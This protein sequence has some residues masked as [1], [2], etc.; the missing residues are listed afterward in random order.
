MPTAIGRRSVQRL[1]SRGATLIDVLPEE[2]FENEHIAGAIHI[3][4][5]NL[6]RQSTSQLEKHEPVIVYCWD[7]QCDLSERASWRL[8]SLGFA[9]V[10]DYEAGE[11]DWLAYG[12]PSEGKK[13]SAARVTSAMRTDVPTCRLHDRIGE[14]ATKVRAKG[15]EVCVVVNE[16]K[17]VLGLLYGDAWNV[18][19]SSLVEDIMSNGPPTTRPSTFLDEMVERLKRRNTP[20]I[21]ISSSNGVLMG[22]LWTSEAEAALSRNHRARTWTD[23]DCSPS[24]VG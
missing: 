16:E 21:L 7:L 17:V 20:G 4:L 10:Y 13:S 9:D 22:Y 11:M 24:E 6:D 12:L 8:E 18:E 5:R 2:E 3:S 14:V 23:L 1:L 19:P 15:W